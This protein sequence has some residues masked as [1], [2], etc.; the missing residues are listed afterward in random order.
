VLP[1]VGYRRVPAAM[2]LA[3]SMPRGWASVAW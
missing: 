3:G 2:D 1:L